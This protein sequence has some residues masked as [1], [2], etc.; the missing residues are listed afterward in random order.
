MRSGLEVFDFKEEDEL[1]EY[2]AGKILSKFKNP[3]LDNPAFLKCNFLECVAQGSDVV[4]NES[5][6]ITCVDVDAI[7]CGNSSNNATTCASLEAVREESTTKEGNSH[8]DSDFP[9]E[10]L[11]HEKDSCSKMEN[12]ESKS[13]FTEPEGGVSCHEAPLPEKIQSNCALAGSPS[14]NVP[15]SNADGSMNESSRSPPASNAAKN[16]AILNGHSSN[17]HFR[18]SEMDIINI[19]V[20]YVVYRDNYCTGCLVTFSRVGIKI[21]GTPTYGDQGTFSFERGIDDIIRIES[22]H[23]Q[24]FETATVKLHLLSKDD[25]QA[26]NAYGVEQLEFAVVEPNWSGKLEEITALN[27]K[28]LALSVMVHDTDVSMDERSDLLRQ[29]P[30]FPIFDE[31]VEDVVYPKGDSDAV[32]ICK[33]DFDL[34]QP[35]T[36]INDTIIDFYIKYLKNQIPPEE[37]HRFHFFNSFFF[38][39]LADLDKDPSSVSDGRAAFLRV[40]KWTRKVDLFGKDYVF[41]PVNF[42]LHWSLLVICHP[43]EV[44]GFEDEDLGKSLRVPCILHMDSIKGNHAGLKNLVQSYLWEEWKSRQKETSEDLSSKFLNLR[45]VPLELPQQENSFDCGLFLV[46]YLELF[47]AEAPL[48][49]SPFK[50]NE[51]SKFLN[52]DWFP[53]AEASLKRTL[54]QRLI[55]ELLENHSRAISSGVCSDEPDSSFPENEKERGVQLVSEGCTQAVACHGNFSGSDASQGIE[56]TLLEAS[57]T[58]NS[59]C[60][61]DP[62][63]R[64]FFEPG[65]AGGSLLAQC[66][67]FDQPSYY[68]LNGALSQQIEQDDAETGEPFMYFPSGDAI[69]QQVPQA[70]SIPYPLRG[71][72]TNPS[73]NPGIA[74]QGEDDGSSPE[75]SVCASDDS[76]VGI[77]ENCPIEKDLDLCQK[78]KIVQQRSQS[79]EN[80]ESLTDRLAASS[81][82]M[83]DTSDI[84]GTGDPDRMHDA[85]ENGD[86]ALYQENPITLHKEPDMVE[87]GLENAGV[88][89]GDMQ[90]MV[91][92]VMAE[93]EVENGLH[94]H[95]EKA[96]ITAGDMQTMSDDVMAVSDEKQTIKDNVMVESDEKQTVRDNVM[97]ESNEKQ[98]VEDNA[99]AE[100]DEQ[101][102]AKRLRVTAPQEAEGDVTGSL[103]KDLHLQFR[104]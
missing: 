49:F 33:R 95:S 79:M 17:N 13:S 4:K 74:M 5:G 83:L 68:R 70:G 28:Y 53:S 88:T 37:K 90:T 47:L 96:E 20:D 2:S 34:L 71:F 14:N 36:F 22:Q 38:R 94:Q 73:W 43:G 35:E 23:L 81:S 59:D 85:N 19:A 30:Y 39:K 11:S 15:K 1:A 78:E 91:D 67:S 25:A 99:M 12:Y 51:R 64:E 80:V 72:G 54:I 102:A 9:S 40:H 18:A 7:E 92:D 82:E 26:A 45:F 42:N 21:S 50:I 69:Y 84:K 61:N 65:V 86:L 48:N 56:I 24:R 16:G 52:V 41:I 104:L 46:H 58:R 62:V 98:T 100:S 89:S 87:N 60:A 57:S 101:Q 76:D 55:S 3:S 75:A 29:R 8:P 66:S 27:V 32:S 44:A 93:S 77:I 97:A 31:A 6:A 10:S 103:S 63:L